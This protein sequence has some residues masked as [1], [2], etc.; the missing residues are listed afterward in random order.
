MTY[1][2]AYLH[3]DTIKM[4]AGE[5]GKKAGVYLRGIVSTT[6]NKDAAINFALS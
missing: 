5:L 4:Y 6:M 1:R 3:K 2:G